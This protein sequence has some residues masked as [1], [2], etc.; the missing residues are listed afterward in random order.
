MKKVTI[1]IGRAL[2]LLPL[3]AG[4]MA[5]ALVSCVRHFV[6]AIAEGYDIGKNL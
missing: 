3:A 6:A 1:W 4:W 2:L 5:G